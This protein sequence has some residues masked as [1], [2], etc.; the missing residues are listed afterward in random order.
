MKILKFDKQIHV[1]K[2][3]KFNTIYF[4]L[5]YPSTYKKEDMGK[6]SLVKQN[7]MNSSKKYP[8]EQEYKKEYQKSFIINSKLKTVRINTNLFI[9][10]QLTVPDPKKVKSFDLDK[11]FQFFMDTIYFPNVT[12]EAFDEYQFNREKEFIQNS[13][14]NSSKNIRDVGYQKFITYIDE[15]GIL[16]DNLYHNR[17]LLD[18]VTPKSLYEFYDK[19][20]LQIEPM[21][22]VYGDIEEEKVQEMFSKYIDISPKTIEIEKN[23]NCFLT[24]RT[25]TQFIE[26]NSN[27]K[28]SAL[29]MGY[30]ILDMK[31]EDTIYLRLL[32]R[33]LDGG[34]N[35][36]LF[37]ALRLEHN[38]VYGVS[39]SDYFKNGMFFIETYLKASS[40]EEAIEAIKTTLSSLREPDFV[41]ECLDKILIA[42]KYNLIRRKDSKYSVL[43]D[44]LDKLAELDDTLEE[45]YE[46]Y[47]N[48]DIDKFLEFLDR[49]VLDTVYFLRGDESEK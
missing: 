37:K 21:I 49:V 40:K 28:Q 9:E 23:Y 43:D 38:L 12:N 29:Y 35:D 1:I 8:T 39:M 18:E 19:N 46:K 3:D 22:L 14:E 25:E 13:I 32:S 36:L 15:V 41:K 44:Y 20:V 47:E 42:N 4:L 17:H 24:P 27:F 11:A 2:T 34:E 45:I 10:A 48:L 31:E 16:K 5:I 33:I 30:K 7:V 6:F 26:E